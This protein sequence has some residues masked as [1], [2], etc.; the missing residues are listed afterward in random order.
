[1][2]DAA[3]RW[4]RRLV[5]VI[6]ALAILGLLAIPLHGKPIIM[7]LMEGAAAIKN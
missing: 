3:R 6:F 1:M 5:R 4:M 7:W 2:K